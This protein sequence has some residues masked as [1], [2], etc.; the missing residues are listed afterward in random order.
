MTD[1]D[2]AEDIERSK[3]RKY[4]EMQDA[5]VDGRITEDELETGLGELYQSG[6]NFMEHVGE[7]VSD[8]QDG[9][10]HHFQNIMDSMVA[11][12]S[13]N[14]SLVCL[15]IMVLIILFEVVSPTIMVFPL[16][17]YLFFKSVQLADRKT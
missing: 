7:D 14:I 5:Y 2:V 16:A 13:N 4:E 1:T 6:D 3:A 17:L 11:W 8:E 9:V 15:V 12:M 10:F